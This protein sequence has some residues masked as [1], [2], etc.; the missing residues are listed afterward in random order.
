MVWRHLEVT[1]GDRLYSRLLKKSESVAL[2]S[3]S[4]LTG[5]GLLCALWHLCC[6][7]HIADITHPQSV[8]SSEPRSKKM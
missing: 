1:A 2:L 7:S 3:T 8:L 5:A 6:F 4:L